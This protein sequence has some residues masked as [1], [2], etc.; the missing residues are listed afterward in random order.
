[1]I[2]KNFIHDFIRIHSEQLILSNMCS[3]VCVMSFFCQNS[4]QTFKEDNHEA[5][6]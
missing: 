6:Y 3:N 2:L 4:A 5:Y 1:M